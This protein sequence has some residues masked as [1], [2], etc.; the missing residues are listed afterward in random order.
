MTRFQ[1]IREF[2]TERFPA[3]CYEAFGSETPHVLL[4]AEQ[5]IME[6][7]ESGDFDTAED[8]IE[9]L[10]QQIASEGRRRR[11]QAVPMGRIRFTADLEYRFS[12]RWHAVGREWKEMGQEC[13][14]LD[15]GKVE[16]LRK[17]AIRAFENEEWD[18]CER[19]CDQAEIEWVRVRVELETR[20]AARSLQAPSTGTLQ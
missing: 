19:L 11:L 7:T 14:D 9:R 8:L 18:R 5:R 2:I 17:E 15:I 6:R 3:L 1:K 16:D 20:I 10:P 13:K 4:E 12:V